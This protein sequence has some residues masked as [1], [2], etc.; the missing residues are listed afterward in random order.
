MKNIPGKWDQNL[1]LLLLYTL[2][3]Y[4]SFFFILDFFYYE[5][6]GIPRPHHWHPHCRCAD[7]GLGWKSSEQ[8]S[9]SLM[10][11]MS[12]YRHSLKTLLVFS[13]YPL[14]C[15]PFHPST[16]RPH[17]VTHQAEVQLW[18]SSVWKPPLVTSDLKVPVPWV[19]TWFMSSLFDL[20]AG[21]SIS[22]SLEKR[23]GLHGTKRP[24]LS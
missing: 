4:I 20:G 3:I 18:S 11:E 13:I 5:K 22:C 23:W 17:D 2:Y 1:P 14:Q 8:W 9:T 15:L 10:S 19:R 6:L 12:M 7:Q 16:L 21:G 24:A